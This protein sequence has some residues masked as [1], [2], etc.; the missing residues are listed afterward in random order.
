MST[1]YGFGVYLNN[2]QPALISNLQLGYA[3]PSQSGNGLYVNGTGAGSGLII[4]NVT[5]TNRGTGVY[6][7]NPGALAAVTGNNLSNDSNGLQL[8]NGADLTVTNNTLTNDGNCAMY[9]DSFTANTHTFPVNSSGN[10]VTGSNNGFQLWNLGTLTAPET[11]GTSGTGIV[12]SNANDGFQTA[13]GNALW[14]R[15]DPNVGTIQGLNLRGTGS[16]AH[17]GAGIYSDGTIGD[18]LVIQNDTINNRSIAINLQYLG[19]DALITNNNFSN[20]NGGISL[21]T[22]TDLTV[23]NNNL[24][25]DSSYAL[26]VNNF[27]AV[28]Q[29]WPII[30]NTN[31]VA[32]SGD[33]ID[34]ANIGLSGNPETIGVTPGSYGIV[35]NNT[36][37]GFQ[38]TSGSALNLNNVPD[39]G[40]INGLNLSWTGSASHSGYGINATTIGGNLVL[41]NIT[42]TNRSQGIDVNGPGAGALITTNTLSNDGTPLTLMNGT[43]LTVTGNNLTYS[44]SVAMYLDTFSASNQTDPVIASNNSV[45]GSSG[46]GFQL[47]NLGTSAAPE[48]ISKSGSGI[49]ISNSD[50]FQTVGFI[51]LYLRNLPN[52]TIS[53]VN[54]S[55]TGEPTGNYGIYQDGGLGGAVTISD[56][57]ANNR[58][59]GIYL[60]NAGAD[61]VLSNNTLTNDSQYGLNINNATDLTVNNNNLSSDGIAMYFNSINASSQTYPVDAS[62]NIV[63]GS[64]IGLYLANTASQSISTSGSGIVINNATDGFQTVSNIPLYIVNLP[65]ATISNVDLSWSGSGRSGSGIQDAG[66]IGAG[67]TISNVNASNRGNGFYFDSGGQDLTLNNNTLN[68]DNQ[69]L[70]ANGFTASGTGLFT[71]VPIIG[72]SNSVANSSNGFFLY[73]MTNVLVGTSGTGFIVNNATDGF[74][75]VT[76]EALRLEDMPGATISGLNLSYGGSG[77]PGYGIFSQ[78]GMGAGVTITN[79]AA[80]N[81]NQGI[82]VTDGYYYTNISATITN[83]NLS[84]DSGDGIYLEGRTSSGNNSTGLTVNNNNL[85]NDGTAMY[86]SDFQRHRYRAFTVPVVASGNTVAGSTNGFNLNNL[87][88]QSIGASSAGILIDNATDGFQTVRGTALYV[89]SSNVTVTGLDLSWTGSYSD[90]ALA[91]N[92][93]GINASGSS[94]AISQVI[95]AGRTYGVA[96]SGSTLSIQNSSFSN[97]YQGVTVSDG[98]DTAL[99]NQNYIV[100]NTTGLVV[101]GGSVQVNATANYWGPGGGARA[102]GNNGFTGSADV[103]SPLASPPA[104]A[105]AIPVKFVVNTTTDDDDA[106]TP[107]SI[108][109][110]AAN[111]G[112]DGTISLREAILAANATPGP[113]VITFA[114]PGGG[115]QTITLGAALPAITGT[116]TIDGTSEP[117]YANVPLIT[118]DDNGLNNTA[119]TVSGTGD[120]LEAL[121]II[122]APTTAVTIVSATNAFLKQMTLSDGGG[123]GTGLIVNSSSNVLAQDLTIN[124]RTTGI[125]LAPASQNIT[126]VTSIITNNTTGVEVS[127]TPTG[128]ALN[129]DEFQGNSTAVVNGGPQVDATNSYWGAANGPTN[130]GGSGNGYTG[131]VNASPFL[132]AVP[133]GITASA[134]PLATVTVNTTADVVDGNTSSIAALARQPRPRQQDLA[135]RGHHRHQRQRRRH[136]R[137]R[138]RHWRSDYHA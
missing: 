17:T 86:L 34:L 52:A 89:N 5:A 18:N 58:S 106:G 133:Q 128:V 29:T 84:N 12:I 59:Y 91:N 28:S 135:A 14:L 78:Y 61:A 137:L 111:P 116:L 93:Y 90:N 115:A 19:A 101:Q 125:D 126:V 1:V 20:N 117:G 113:S 77:H 130:L 138:H 99:V 48:T 35:I 80:A 75:T 7:G 92:S 46:Y 31:N 68:N 57:T 60:Q 104:G 131:N 43:D 124:D 85:A 102:G 2:S 11:I 120:V 65:N 132:T 55:W 109:A 3:G 100:G 107:S 88:G 51:A 95:A 127:A 32:G 30:A 10:I 73:A 119:L 26:S 42:A 69:S 21:Y 36:N 37:D 44:T 136:H 15:N 45:T 112:P 38:T 72:T 53:N 122:N 70:Y 114:I 27:T 54:L 82:I 56:V 22:G 62:G 16:S 63:A 105:P 87:T 64:S 39:V 129:Q 118:I 76:G 25:N 79:V 123:S 103:S 8:I 81:R 9:L 83:N 6:F 108:Y 71:T 49:V 98:T 40:T 24:T 13:S 74:Q 134:P 97:D 121:N 94:V 47:F 110:L 4:Q 96:L 67:V 33:G 50:G 66:Y 41:E 23:T